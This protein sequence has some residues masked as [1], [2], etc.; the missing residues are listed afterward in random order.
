MAASAQRREREQICVPVDPGLRAAI[1][2]AAQSEHRTVAS[3]VRHVLATALEHRTGPQRE[4][5]R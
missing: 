2:R 4:A 5:V 3:L 1:E